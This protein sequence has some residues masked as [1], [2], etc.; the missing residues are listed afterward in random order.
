M[1]KRI[2]VL[3]MFLGGCGGGGESE[4]VAVAS[5]APA[6]NTVV[7]DAGYFSDSS[8]TG[9]VHVTSTTLGRFTTIEFFPTY[10]GDRLKLYTTVDNSTGL[11]V[12]RELGGHY[13]KMIVKD[14]VYFVK[15]E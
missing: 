13:G 6:F 11:V 15:G 12:G 14:V 1:W 4:P 7:K 8:S 10:H 9:G 5:P 2:A 3:A